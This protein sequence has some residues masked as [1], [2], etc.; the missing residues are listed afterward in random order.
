MD[1]EC[2]EVSNQIKD[3]KKYGYAVMKINAEKTAIVL[4]TKGEKLADRQESTTKES[5]DEM[6]AFVLKCEEPRYILADI[7]YDR[8]GGG[9]NDVVVYIYW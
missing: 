9:R 5:F 8:K 1:S 2:K 3:N 6:R 4:E 7:T